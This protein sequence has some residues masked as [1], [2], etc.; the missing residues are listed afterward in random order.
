M[1]HQGDDH[2]DVEAL[3][4]NPNGMWGSTYRVHSKYDSLVIGLG[5]LHA[6]PESPGKTPKKISF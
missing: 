6:I 4:Y 1:I 3:D 5:C 2:G